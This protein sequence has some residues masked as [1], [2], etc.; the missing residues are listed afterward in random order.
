MA[1]RC[2][3]EGHAQ[4]KVVITSAGA[5]APN[6]KPSSRRADGV[7]TLYGWG[8]HPFRA[9]FPIGILADLCVQD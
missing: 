8:H 1:L 5:Q 6:T 2:L 7:H 4:G 9:L 3:D